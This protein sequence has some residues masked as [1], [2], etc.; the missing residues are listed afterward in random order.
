M[1]KHTA[2][3][4]EDSGSDEGDVNTDD[5]RKLLAEDDDDDEPPPTRTKVSKHAAREEQEARKKK[6]KD[7]P[8][9]EEDEPP[10]QE[11]SQKKKKKKR[12][13]AADPDDATS[14]SMILQA[15]DVMLSFGMMRGLETDVCT[16][17]DKTCDMDTAIQRLNG[18]DD[19][20]RIIVHILTLHDHLQQLMEGLTEGQDAVRGA[21]GILQPDTPAKKK[22]PAREHV[23][24]A[25]TRI[26]GRTLTQAK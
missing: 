12:H 14:F 9:S 4:D 2:F 22:K 16:Y 19:G 10:P 23:S 11:E 21:G 26:H 18:T 3:V 15:D 5:M 7:R 6:K 8:P 13:N 17:R 24:E 20:D 25:V 1:S